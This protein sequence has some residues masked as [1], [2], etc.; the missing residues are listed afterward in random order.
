MHP[1][2]ETRFYDLLG[3]KLAGECKPAELEELE[4]ILLRHPELQLFYNQIEKHSADLSAVDIETAY[5]AH[6]EKM[7][8]AP[9]QEETNKV[10]RLSGGY[11]SLKRLVVAAAAIVVLG[12][13]WLLL[14]K[15]KRVADNKQTIVAT[16]RDSRSTMT[17]PDGS[18]VRL[19][20]K[21]KVSYGEGF[22]KTTRE[23]FLTGEAYFEVT[24]NASVPF[25]VHTEEADIKVLGTQFNVRNYSN[26]RKM[27]AALL[28]GSIELTVHSDAGHKIL[29]K[30]SDKIIVKK[31]AA[32]E[33][34]ILPDSANKKVELTRIK[35]QDSV[36]VETS[37][38]NDKMAF[39]DKP[40]SEIALDLERQFD[41]SIVFKNKEVSGYKYT[42][43]YDEANVEEIL[44]I[45]QMIK[46][47]Q[48]TLNNK[49]ITIY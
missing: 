35:L 25:I 13:T 29:L 23:V 8:P 45:L 18:V 49:Q 19:N 7:F 26:E 22:G 44:K 6:R 27:E 1:S 20:A 17:L 10:I 39:Y 41:V 34:A 42:G 24:H 2:V 40:F 5:T 4:N 36:I 32:G 31:N 15:D 12:L 30:P 46:P 21:S 14:N 9:S 38:L 37:W 11:F 28:T 47:F 48:Y 16:G 3:R 43:V 33:S